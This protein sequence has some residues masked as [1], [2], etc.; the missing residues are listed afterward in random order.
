MF[1]SWKPGNR[2]FFI[3]ESIGSGYDEK[4]TDQSVFQARVKKIFE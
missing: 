1:A 4:P 2:L 3:D